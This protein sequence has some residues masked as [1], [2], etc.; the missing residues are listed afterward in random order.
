LGSGFAHGKDEYKREVGEDA[1]R[2]LIDDVSVSWIAD[3]EA[4]TRL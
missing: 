4:G 1:L 2:H 3:C